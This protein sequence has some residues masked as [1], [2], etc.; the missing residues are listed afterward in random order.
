M[1]QDVDND[2]DTTKNGNDK[3]RNRRRKIFGLRIGR[4]DVNYMRFFSG[5]KKSISEQEVKI[6]TNAQP[7]DLNNPQPDKYSLDLAV[8]GKNHITASIKVAGQPDF[9]IKNSNPAC[10][11]RDILRC[12]RIQYGKTRAHIAYS[13]IKGMI[14][15]AKEK[16]LSLTYNAPNGHNMV[17]RMDNNNVV[18][19]DQDDQTNFGGNKRRITEV[20]FDY[21]LFDN[22]NTFEGATN[23]SLRQGIDKLMGHFNKAMN[24]THEQYRK[25][26]EKKFFTKTHLPTSAWTSPIKKLLN[27]RTTTNFDFQTTVT[28]ANGK[29]ASVVFKENMF[30]ISGDGIKKPISSKSLGK[31]LGH[32]E[33]RMRVFDGIERDICGGVYEEIIKKMRENS[34]IARSNF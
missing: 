23:R 22:T 4:R 28:G 31:L 5:A 13:V 29:K 27:M 33:G 15:M 11:V 20:L 30:T 8:S 19:E 9:A 10:L 24:Q 17:V 18:L 21:K 26:T 12:P 3:M 6:N 7:E 32:R 34:K 14:E 25:A 2:I 1:H 16:D